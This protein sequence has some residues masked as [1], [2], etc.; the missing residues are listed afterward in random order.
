MIKAII[1][2]FD[3]VILESVDVKTQAYR[4][5]F[6][7]YTN[8][9]EPIIN[10]HLQNNGVSRYIKFKYIWETL[11]GRRYDDKARHELG[12][13]FSAI[14]MDG[15]LKS[16]FVNGALE[17]LEGF[18]GRAYLYVASAVPLEELADIIVKKNIKKYF[19]GVYG[20]PPVTKSEAIHNVMAREAA[21]QKEIV[22]VG[23]SLKD[24]EAAR[25]AGVFFIARKNKEDFS[26]CAVPVFDDLTGVEGY[27]RENFEILR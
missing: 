19:K 6:L 26:S 1:L 7:R 24:L 20:F 21:S 18:Y 27:I 11:L 22:F 17:F 23:D 8:D 2:D 25:S 15:V 10:Y 9:I 12:A 16:P 3:G 14:V 4:D 13:G 5:L